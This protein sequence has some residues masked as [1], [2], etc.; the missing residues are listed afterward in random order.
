MT[1]QESLQISDRNVQIQNANIHYLE[2]GNTE[3]PSILFLHGASFS[4]KTWEELGSLVWFAQQGYHAVSMDLPGYGK[5]QKTTIQPAEF[6]LAFLEA[7]GL[8]QPVIVSPSMSGNYS[9]PFIIQYPQQCRGWVAVA[10]VGINKF[11][12]QLANVNLPVLAIWGSNDRIVPTKQAD[13]LEQNVPNVHKVILEKAG[14]ACYMRATDEFHNH[15]LQFCQN[16]S[17]QKN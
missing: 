5:S 10:P 9:L 11:K 17:Q 13:V 6:L 3:S 8:S 16:C 2:A 14:H 1:S 7:T 12:Q 4:A 15:L